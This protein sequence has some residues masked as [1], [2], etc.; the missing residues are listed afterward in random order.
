MANKF[1]TE[2]LVCNTDQETPTESFYD[3]VNRA[4]IKTMADMN[5]SVKVRDKTISVP[6]EVMYLRLLAINAEKKVP[7]QEYFPLRMQL[8][9]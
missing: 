5:K 6:G 1:V 7:Q 8:S 2:Q 3:T 4:N 9:P